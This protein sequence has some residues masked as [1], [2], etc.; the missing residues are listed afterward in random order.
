LPTDPPDTEIQKL[1]KKLI[2]AYFGTKQDA[3]AAAIE[4]ND[5]TVN[6]W[7]NGSRHPGVDDLEAILSASLMGHS[8][9][10]PLIASWT[11]EALGF[12]GL[13]VQSLTPDNTPRVW[14]REQLDRSEAETRLDRAVLDRD[15]VAFEAA[16]EE[17]E[18]EARER[19]AAGRQRLGIDAPSLR[20]AR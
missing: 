7:V 11:L 2:R 9:D 5:S 19:I 10:K 6:R 3:L 17:V 1:L 18:T 8:E 14:E 15:P 16:A 4:V 20:V 12:R 13:Q